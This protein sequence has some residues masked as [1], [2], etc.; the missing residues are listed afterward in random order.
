MASVPVGAFEPLPLALR[1]WAVPEIALEPTVGRPPSWVDPRWLLVFDSETRLDPGLA[2]TFGV[3]RAFRP[4]SQ[5]SDTGTP[6]FECFGEWIFYGD[7][8]TDDELGILEDAVF[9]QPVREFHRRYWNPVTHRQEQGGRE[10]HVNDESVPLVLL[11]RAEFVDQVFLPMTQRA[12]ALIVGF[13]LPFDLSR[14]AIKWTTTRR[15]RRRRNPDDSFAARRRP[16]DTFAGGFSMV[17]A[18]LQHAP[19]QEDRFAPR[20]AVKTI[21]PKRHLIGLRG[22]EEGTNPM[23]PDETVKFR[24]H[25]LDLRTLAFALTNTSYDLRRACRDFGVEHGKLDHEPTGRVTPDEL[26]YGRRDVVATYELA[27]KLLAEYQRHPIELARSGPRQP[28]H[29][30]LPQRPS[31]GQLSSQ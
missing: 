2:L 26:I 10:V 31:R 30:H 29:P 7:A 12:K 20:V 8:I 19:G 13:N 23:F 24:G 27:V 11:S 1:A 5:P 3:A 14:L 9:G 6:A 22:G 15:E 16:W 25:F 18:D 28:C 21:D 17:L 4:K